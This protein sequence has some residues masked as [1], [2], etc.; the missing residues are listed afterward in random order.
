MMDEY[1]ILCTAR[2]DYKTIRPVYIY[3]KAN[4]Q[5]SNHSIGKMFNVSETVIWIWFWYL[6]LDIPQFIPCVMW[7][8]EMVGP[9]TKSIKWIVLT[10]K[11]PEK[12][13]NVWFGTDACVHG[14]HFD[15]YWLSQARRYTNQRKQE[16]RICLCFFRI[17]KCNWNLIS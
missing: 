17:S 16:K 13:K 14:K 11:S 3:Y 15:S 8:K 5:K 1:R 9:P 2:R 4:I 6:I 10:R 7:N 12:K